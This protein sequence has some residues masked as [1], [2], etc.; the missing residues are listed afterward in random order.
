LFRTLECDSAS[1]I[2]SLLR[3]QKS[4]TYLSFWKMVSPKIIWV[5]HHGF[6]ASF[7][8]LDSILE[9]PVEGLEEVASNFLL[10][11][12]EKIRQRAIENALRKITKEGGKGLRELRSLVSSINYDSTSSKARGSNRERAFRI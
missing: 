10:D 1:Y 6:R 8:N 2:L 12:E 3:P 11:V 4:I 7:R 9:T 5:C